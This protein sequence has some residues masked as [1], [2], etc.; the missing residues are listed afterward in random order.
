MALHPAL[1]DHR[2]HRCLRCRLSTRR[3][4]R[5][6]CGRGFLVLCRW[7]GCA[8]VRNLLEDRSALLPGEERLEFGFELDYIMYDTVRV[9]I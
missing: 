5:Y 7:S 3:R 4:E 1:H 8:I 2:H 6:F 9:R